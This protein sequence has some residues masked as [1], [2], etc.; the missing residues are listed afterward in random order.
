TRDSGR[1]LAAIGNLSRPRHKALH[2]LRHRRQPHLQ[3]ARKS[4]NA[5]QQS[6]SFVR[7]SPNLGS[8]HLMMRKSAALAIFLTIT[9]PVSALAQSHSAEDEAA[10]T[11]DVLSLCQ[12]YIPNRQEII[13]CL[14]ARKQ[15]LSPACFAVFSRPAPGKKAEDP[16]R[17]P[18]KPINQ[19]GGN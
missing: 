16:R 11:P 13:G 10:C 12:Q 17:P 6:R 19:P 2:Q 7:G 18:R 3:S 5:A 4:D 15:E 1:N 8:E 9:A 14:N